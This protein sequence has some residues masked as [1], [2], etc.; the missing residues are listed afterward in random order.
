[1]QHHLARIASEAADYWS[2]ARQQDDHVPEAT[3]DFDDLRRPRNLIDCS[4]NY[5][6]TIIVYRYLDRI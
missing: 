1:M 3:A 4:T 2:R 6:R 5:E